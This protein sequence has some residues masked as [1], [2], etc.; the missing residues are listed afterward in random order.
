MGL[1]NIISVGFWLYLGTLAVIAQT[2][3][4]HRQEGRASYYAGKFSGRKTASGELFNNEKMT[5]AHPKLP[6]N[7]MIKVTNPV[8][9]HSC[10]L[11]IN[12]RGPFTKGRMLDI[13]RCAARQ[14]GIIQAGSA[15][16]KIEVIGFDGQIANNHKEVSTVGETVDLD[17]TL[18]NKH[19]EDQ[20]LATIIAQQQ[21][22]IR[23]VAEKEEEAV[24]MLASHEDFKMDK[25]YSLQG[26]EISPIGFGIQVAS[27]TDLNN[28]KDTAK[29]LAYASIKDVFI[30]VT[31]SEGEKEF[32]V[33]VGSFM[34]R[35]EAKRFLAVTEQAGFRGIVKKHLE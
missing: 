27:F 35:R 24:E 29:E 16:V 21:L 26:T 5:A 14:L 18:L 13:S 28:A 15:I 1:K 32:Q 23:T 25:S 22:E 3:I 34:G 20:K 11:R 12:D 6:F 30:Q 7:T 4:G 9:G 10:I 19:G 31:G 8:N 17:A 33:L 2:P